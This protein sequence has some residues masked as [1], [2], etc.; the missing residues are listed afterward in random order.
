MYV[1]YID[2]GAV[3]IRRNYKQLYEQRKADALRS[4]W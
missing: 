1:S 4:Q 2:N 3:Y